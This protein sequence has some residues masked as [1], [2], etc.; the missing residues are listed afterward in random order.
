MYVDKVIFGDLL[1]SN[2][3]KHH[4]EITPQRIFVHPNYNA[5]TYDSD[6][7]VI[8]LS[9]PV[10][11]TDHVRPACLAESVNETSAYTR[12]L[13]SGWGNTEIGTYACLPYEIMIVTFV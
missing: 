5:D 13:I 6:I 10:T 7:A 4:V 3:S 2:H 8:K 9:H 12:C 1:L 11:F